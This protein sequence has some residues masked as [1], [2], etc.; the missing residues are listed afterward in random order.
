MKKFY[1]SLML[2]SIFA[3]SVS[4]AAPL[5]TDLQRVSSV[6]LE[7][8]AMVANASDAV[9]S[10]ATRADGTRALSSV[11]DICGPYTINSDWWYP[12]EGNSGGDPSFFI[13]K[14]ADDMVEISV[15]EMAG[16][17]PLLAT[18]N[19]SAGTITI[20]ADDNKNLYSEATMDLELRRIDFNNNGQTVSVASVTG[21][22]E[23]DG[24][25][26]FQDAVLLWGAGDQK[27][28]YGIGYIVL[29]P[30]SFFSYNASDWAAAGK[31]KF[32]DGFLNPAFPA[33]YRQPAMDVDLY[34]S[35]VTD[36]EYLLMN[37]YGGGDWPQILDGSVP[38]YIV[39]N[40]SNPDC[41]TMSPLVGSG[42]I[43]DMRQSAE[44]PADLQELFMYNN[45]GFRLFGGMSTEAQVEEVE[46]AMNPFTETIADY[47]SVYDADTRTVNFRNGMFGLGND[48]FAAYLWTS[49]DKS[50]GL[51]GTIVLP[52]EAGV[53]EAIANSDAPVKFYNLQGM[54][55]AN[56]EAGQIV[57]KKQ[58]GKTVKVIA[59]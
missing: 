44:A 37:P 42:A 57:I 40:I 38:G 51:T 20:K 59:E 24:R 12:L 28:Y 35:K 58:G 10:V 19:L 13:S 6:S 1:S 4:A 11:D 48:P 15:S 47:L 22:V 53:A 41:V 18:V 49:T 55:V 16:T 56:P 33:E 9:K 32:T 2:A 54:E 46:E 14:V 36:G 39:F 23:A 34:K 29:S 8:K 25:L 31:A 52:D 26:N 3:A 21:T 50:T 5:A 7:K 30:V 27:Y 43:L 45:E 17:T